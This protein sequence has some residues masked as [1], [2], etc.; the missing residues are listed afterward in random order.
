MKKYEVVQIPGYH[1]RF[2]VVVLHKGAI[3]N[4][5]RRLLI[6]NRDPVKMK[7]KMKM[8]KKILKL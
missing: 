4:G 8:K 1:V 2:T 7:M 5:T 6:Q 3:I